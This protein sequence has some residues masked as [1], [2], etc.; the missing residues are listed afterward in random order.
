MRYLLLSLLLVSCASITPSVNFIEFSESETTQIEEAMADLGLENRMEITYIKVNLPDN[1]LGRAP[2]G[3]PQCNIQLSPKNFI[4]NPPILKTV[5]WHEIGH[6]LGMGHHES[7]RDIM[8]SIAKPFNFYNT[9]DIAGFKRRAVEFNNR[10]SVIRQQRRHIACG[11][12]TGDEEQE[13]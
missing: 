8:Y 11:D 12:L 5:V 10:F 7:P 13:N 6:C 2:V 9:S 4:Y 1:I 3:N